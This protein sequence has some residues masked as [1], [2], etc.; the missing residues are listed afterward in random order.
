MASRKKIKADEVFIKEEFISDYIL[1]VLNE[2]SF[3]DKH[4]GFFKTMFDGIENSK[5][6]IVYFDRGDLTLQLNEIR[7][8]HASYN[9]S[10][11]YEYGF[12]SDHDFLVNQIIQSKGV[13]SEKVW[14]ALVASYYGVTSFALDSSWPATSRYFFAEL[15]P[16]TINEKNS[17]NIVG[18]EGEQSVVS[19]LDFMHQK[20]NI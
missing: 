18:V 12:V 10:N 7:D 11:K 4:A 16:F 2:L 6:R 5:I 3:L 17:A 9:S 1:L 8:L 15:H 13:I 19:F 20:F 14:P